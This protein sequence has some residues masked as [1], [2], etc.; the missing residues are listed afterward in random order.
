MIAD[1]LCIWNEENYPEFDVFMTKEGKITFIESSEMGT[2]WFSLD[3]E[4]WGFVKN[5][6]DAQFKAIEQKGQQNG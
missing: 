1:K 4:D 2:G 6:I 5:F 3:K